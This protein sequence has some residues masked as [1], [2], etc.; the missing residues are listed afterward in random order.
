MCPNLRII[1]LMGLFFNFTPGALS[2]DYPRGKDRKPAAAGRFYPADARE[3]RADLATLFSE[4]KPRTMNNV[5]AVVCPHAGYVFSGKVAASGY[6]QV[7]PDRQF[8]NVF[9]IASSHQVSFQGASIYNKGDYVTPLGEVKVN[10]EL[11]NV[12]PPSILHTIL[13]T[14]L[15]LCCTQVLNPLCCPALLLALYHCL[16]LLPVVYRQGLYCSCLT[17]IRPCYC[18]YCCD[19]TQRLQFS[20]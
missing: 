20:L 4:A 8:D 15:V 16:V 9:I 10:I 2:Q 19:R 17:A 3:L 5:A 1:L 11:A 12:L 6:N 13:R 7:D 18:V 14:L